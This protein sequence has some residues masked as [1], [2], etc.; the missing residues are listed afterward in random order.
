MLKR[1]NP[2]SALLCITAL[3][4]ATW[5]QDPQPDGKALPG[6][7][8]A[9]F[10]DN[11]VKAREGRLFHGRRE[12]VW[13]GWYEGGAQQ[14][15]GA[16]H[17]YQRVGHWIYWQEN[18]H[19][20]MEGEW[21]GGERVGFHRL[22]SNGLHFH[23][24]HARALDHHEVHHSDGGVVLSESLDGLEI[25]F[26]FDRVNAFGLEHG[27]LAQIPGSSGCRSERQ[28]RENEENC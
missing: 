18:G 2:Q 20:K 17:D 15:E 12:G 5:L 7:V 11:G 8:A 22:K 6:E 28:D 16:F 19:K 3:C 26:S 23:R 13:K 24:L 9:F 1:M 25:L 14:Y 21:R 27:Q 10:H 4:A